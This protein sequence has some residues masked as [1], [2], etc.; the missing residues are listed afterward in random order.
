MD[1]VDHW[2]K[3]AIRVELPGG[4]AMNVR[5]CVVTHFTSGGTAKSSIEFWKT[6]AAK[7]ASA[8]IVI[9]RDGTVYQ[10]RPFNRTCGHAGVS[11][12]EDPITGKL[13]RNINSCSI[14]IELANAGDDTAVQKIAAKLPGY[15]GVVKATHR[16]GGRLAT[17]ELFPPAQLGVCTAVVKAL[18]KE[19]NLDDVTGH[20]CVAPARKLD[21]GPSFPM[22][23]LRAACGFVGLPKVHN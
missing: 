4:E 5:R 16:N 20:D 6:A 18:V 15:A 2:L 9:D 10:C 12:W 23:E 22:R 17:W 11:K 8:H 3:D 7:G 13:Y 19:Y 1:I 14:G 21:P